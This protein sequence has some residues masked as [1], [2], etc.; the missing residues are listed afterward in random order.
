MGRVQPATSHPRTP[1]P[2]GPNELGWLTAYSSATTLRRYYAA[3]YVVSNSAEIL[4]MRRAAR[5]T[6]A[7]GG[8]LRLRQR[9]PAGVDDLRPRVAD[10]PAAVAT[11]PAAVTAG[12]R[13]S[14]APP[15]PDWDSSRTPG[16]VL[17]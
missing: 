16:K 12:I 17:H 8:R 1:G 10:K 14:R 2:P 13:A 5:A 6:R 3:S 15:E 4:V 7:R 9:Q 11:E